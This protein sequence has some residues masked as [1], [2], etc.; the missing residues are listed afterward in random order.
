MSHPLT[1]HSIQNVQLRHHHVGRGIGPYAH[2]YEPAL[3]HANAH[4]NAAA[5]AHAAPPP[6]MN[7]Q[8]Q[9]PMKPHR[10]CGIVQRALP[11]SSTK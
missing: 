8:T 9:M 3:V 6:R 1:Y 11:V 7:M 5:H 4:T 10:T 2:A